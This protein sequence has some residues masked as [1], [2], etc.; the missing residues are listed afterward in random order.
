MPS[1][2]QSTVIVVPLTSWRKTTTWSAAMGLPKRTEGIFLFKGGF[3]SGF[4]S[5][6]FLPSAATGAPTA[7]GAVMAAAVV[8]VVATGWLVPCASNEGRCFIANAVAAVTVRAARATGIF[9]EARV[10]MRMAPF[11]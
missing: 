5:S 8:V 9:R 2:F 4:F 10:F 1:F 6:G 3:G 7:V 11:A